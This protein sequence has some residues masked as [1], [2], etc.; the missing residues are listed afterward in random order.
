M[1]PTSVSVMPYINAHLPKGE[2]SA[3]TGTGYAPHTNLVYYET[4]AP[5]VRQPPHPLLRRVLHQH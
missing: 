1:V 2:K 5:H 4:A 3:G